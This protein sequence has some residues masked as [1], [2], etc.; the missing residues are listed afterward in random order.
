MTGLV[1][2]CKRAAV[3]VR[4]LEVGCEGRVRRRGSGVRNGKD[5]WTLRDAYVNAVRCENSLKTGPQTDAGREQMRGLPRPTQGRSEREMISAQAG[6]I[7]G[8]RDLH[9]I[10]QGELSQDARHRTLNACRLDDQTLGDLG[11]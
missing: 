11:V 5:A 4:R 6:A 8:D 7:P 10:A 3:Q 9:A 2:T 1:R